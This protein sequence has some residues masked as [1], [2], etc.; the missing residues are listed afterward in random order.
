MSNK[1]FV[2]VIVLVAVTTGCTVKGPNVRLEA[3]SVEIGMSGGGTHCPP[4]QSKKG[5]C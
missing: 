3:P 1:S 4:G 2:A 5:R